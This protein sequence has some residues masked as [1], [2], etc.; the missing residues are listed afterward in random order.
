MG[1]IVSLRCYPFPA[2]WPGTRPTMPPPHPGFVPSNLE[3]IASL[4]PSRTVQQ[5]N[6][7]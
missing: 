2:H 4:L 1:R 3:E 7:R 6:I 5:L